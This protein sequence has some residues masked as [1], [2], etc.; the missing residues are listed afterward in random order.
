MA[1]FAK[2]IDGIVIEVIV[3]EQDFIDSGVVGD[4]SSWIQTSYNTRDGIHYDQEGNPDNG[5]ALR[6][7]YAGPGYIYDEENDVF[8]PPQPFPSWK[9][10]KKF[11]R[12]EPPSP[13]PESGSYYWDEET[14]QWTENNT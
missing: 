14:L 9:I 13:K 7:N 5:I 3:A 11:W 6:G 4:P 2:V 8:Y 12:W 1:H 10:N